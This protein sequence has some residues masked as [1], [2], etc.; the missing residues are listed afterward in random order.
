MKRIARIPA[1]RITRVELF[2]RRLP[3]E[4]KDEPPAWK[5]DQETLDALKPS[6]R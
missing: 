4:A 2:D 5:S 3:F 1:E 6:A